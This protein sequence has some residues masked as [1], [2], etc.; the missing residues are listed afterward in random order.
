MGD[1][2]LGLHCHTVADD[3]SRPKLSPS[4]MTSINGSLIEVPHFRFSSPRP[5]QGCGGCD[6]GEDQP[7]S[8]H[9]ETSPR[10]SGFK[11]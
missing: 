7:T 5:D 8:C 4:P 11:T 3:K 6:I 9:A 2:L 1:K 10:G